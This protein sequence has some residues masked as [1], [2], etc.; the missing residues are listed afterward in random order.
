MSESESPFLD[1]LIREGEEL[2]RRLLWCLGALAL[3]AGAL[4]GLPNWEH[5]FALKLAAWL[6]Q[7]LLPA[8]IKLV[9]LDPLEP[10][11]VVL[12]LSL[13]VAFTACS[14]L[15]IWHFL[16]FT[17]PAFEK[18]MRSFYLR[19]TFL[20][21]ALFSLGAFLAAKFL[22]PLTLDML[23]SYGISAGGVPQLTFERFYSFSALV[24][25]AFA[26]PFETPLIMGFLHRF[27]IVTSD[28]FRAWRWKAWGFFMILSQFVTPDPLV[29]PLIFTGLTIFLYELGLRL[30][31]WL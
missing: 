2:R 3:V 19:F 10:M 4:I 5:S 30:S 14:P 18:G 17:M 20:A 29:T 27:N 11:M 31:K 8:G 7:A 1:F 26:L 16:R 28:N 22:L 23:L 24:V 9:F 13:I 25:V 6:Q 21:L 15:F 12:K